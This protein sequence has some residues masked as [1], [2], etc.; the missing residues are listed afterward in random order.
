[1]TDLF[2]RVT[3]DQDVFKKLASYIPGFNGYVERQNRRAADKL[4]RET[5]ANRFEELWKRTSQ[6]QT[7]MVSQGMIALMDDMERASIQLRTFVDKVRTAAYGYSGLFDAVKINEEELAQLYA[8]DAAFFD[9][10][11]QIGHALDNVEAS[12]GDEDGLPAAIRNLIAIAR[13]ATETFNRRSEA[14]T[15]SEK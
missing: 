12:L 14:I 2:E 7:D 6:L 8:F 4:L 1:M 3:G 10:A 13:Q 9:L 11:E 15:G 5:V